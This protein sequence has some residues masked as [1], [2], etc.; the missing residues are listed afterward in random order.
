MK[1]K[2]WRSWC[3]TARKKK[4]FKNKKLLVSRLEGTR[5]DRLLRQC[6]DAIKYGNINRKYEETKEQL[7]REV[8]IREE[9][10]KKRDILIKVG[11][12][13]EKYNLFR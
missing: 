5:S 12:S 4:Y 13:K 1:F 8:P 6:F 10:E 3:E 2:A 11:V 7:E 9:L